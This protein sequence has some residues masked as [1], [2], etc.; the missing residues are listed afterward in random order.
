MFFKIGFPKNFPNFTGKHKFL[1][2]NCSGYF[3]QRNLVEVV[4]ICHATGRSWTLFLLEDVNCLMC[5]L[6]L[7]RPSP[8][9]CK[10][11]H[12]CNIGW[13]FQWLL[14][15]LYFQM[16]L[17]LM[18]DLFH[19]WSIRNRSSHWQL[20]SG[21]LLLVEYLIWNI[22]LYIEAKCSWAPAP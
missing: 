4:A 17:K 3:D 14:N 8:P 15:L 5:H 6:H 16:R 18:Q 13:I 12:R 2:N 7:H 9:S 1:Q 10:H 20:D 22:I 21:L 11:T 19:Y